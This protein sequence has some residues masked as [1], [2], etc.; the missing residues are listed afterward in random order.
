MQEILT[1]LPQRLH[2]RW[3]DETPLHIAARWGHQEV[4]AYLISLGH[5]LDPEDGQGNTPAALATRFGQDQLAA[6]L[7]QRG[8]K[9]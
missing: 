3:W 7:V 5:G 8:G 1:E 2:E 4:A 9:A 6:W